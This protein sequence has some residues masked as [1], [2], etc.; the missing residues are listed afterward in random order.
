MTTI[1]GILM[2]DKPKSWIKPGVCA[3]EGC[4]K[5]SWKASRYCEYHHKF[6]VHN[7]QRTIEEAVNEP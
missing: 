4:L 1:G 3:E 7:I 6:R 5:E 2:N